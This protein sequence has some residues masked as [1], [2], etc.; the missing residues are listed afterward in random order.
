MNKNEYNHGEAYEHSIV[1]LQ[2]KCGLSYREARAY[3]MANWEPV[4]DLAREW[5]VTPE[6]VYNLMRRAEEKIKKSGL[7]DEEIYGDKQLRVMFVDP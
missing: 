5:K 1:A 3:L 4:D 7:T 2:E 6:A